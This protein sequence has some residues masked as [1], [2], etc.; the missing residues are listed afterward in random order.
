[1]LQ[2]VA[3]FVNI[4]GISSVHPDI[5]MIKMYSDRKSYF[6][7]Q[8]LDFLGEGLAWKLHY[9][10]TSTKYSCTHTAYLWTDTLICIYILITYNYKLFIHIFILYAY[11]LV[12]YIFNN[13]M[14]I[15]TYTIYSLIQYNHI[16]ILST[17]ILTQYLCYIYICTTYL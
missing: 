4:T 7:R 17:Y 16:L 14:Y 11:V 5:P 13:S 1:M 12:Y 2:D 9:V 15:Y 6:P 10:N 8:H 3:L